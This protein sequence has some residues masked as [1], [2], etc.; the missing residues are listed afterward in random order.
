[1]TRPPPSEENPTPIFHHHMRYIQI[2]C[3]TDKGDDMITFCGAFWMRGQ[4][5]HGLDHIGIWVFIFRR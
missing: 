5:Q 1:M 3:V 4:G 2:F